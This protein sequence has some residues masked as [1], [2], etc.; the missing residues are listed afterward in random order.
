MLCSYNEP[1]RQRRTFNKYKTVHGG[2]GGRSPVVL[3][4]ET[5]SNTENT[6]QLTFFT[7]GFNL[8]LIKSTKRRKSGKNLKNCFSDVRGPKNIT[9]LLEKSS[10]E[11]HCSFLGKKIRFTI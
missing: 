11:K 4:E 2:I 7:S 1:P 3:W 10:Q 5:A 8:G 6:K 9:Q